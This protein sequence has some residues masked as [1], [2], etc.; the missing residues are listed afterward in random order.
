MH[1]V[2]VCRCVLEKNC[3][4]EI[5]YWPEN[6]RGQTQAGDVRD[7]HSDPR[8]TACTNHVRTVLQT[9]SYNSVTW[10]QAENGDPLLC[11]SGSGAHV[12]NV[13][14]ITSQQLV[15]VCLAALD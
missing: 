1:Q 7:L 3:T 8:P 6:D 11:A 13:F 10:S 4:I 14:N 12:I 5:L 9:I 15:T 2:I